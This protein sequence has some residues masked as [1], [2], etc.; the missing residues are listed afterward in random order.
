MSQHPCRAAWRSAW[1]GLVLL[2]GC[3]ARD[4]V[5]LYVAVQPEVAGPVL[6]RFTRRTC[7]SVRAEYQSART[8][9]A[10][11][12]REQDAPQC[13]VFWDDEMLPT[14]RLA[15][16][17]L[18]Q[19]YASPA[20]GDL[21]DWARSKENLWTG[22]AA[23]VRVALF[24]TQRISDPALRPTTV[25][26][27][28]LPRWRGQAGLAHPQDGTSF[29]HL[30]AL[31]VRQG[32]ETAMARVRAMRD[33]GLRLLPSEEDVCT[34]VAE[35]KLAFGIVDSDR[36]MATVQSGQPVRLAYIDS[37]GIGTLVVPN[38]VA[39]VAGARHPQSARRLIDWLVSRETELL[40]A[41]GSSA[42]VPL[43]PALP[44]PPALRTLRERMK[45]ME[46][47]FE[48]IAEREHAIR[49]LLEQEQ[50]LPQG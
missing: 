48:T 41:R 7:I 5:Y 33:N 11:I 45:G 38:A 40:L 39:M 46:V 12:A 47:Q 2:A 15:R 30:A 24:N 1:L 31:V 28:A 34:Q 25:F 37:P 49:A 43:R 21:P 27:L 4:T 32:T 18:L 22:F 42:Q 44:G 19:P 20:A 3:T 14:V 10:R 13:D 50:L 17:G 23:R 26:A 8:L 6:E 35:G 29:S 36:A 9:E 16:A